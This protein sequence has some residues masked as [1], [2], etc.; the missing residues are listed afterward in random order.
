MTAVRAVLLRP[1]VVLLMMAVLVALVPAR[2]AQAADRRS[3]ADIRDRMEYLVNRERVRHG[4]PRLRVHLAT[5]KRARGHSKDM[6]S[7]GTIYH[8]ANLGNEVPS[9][10]TAYGENVAKT[11]AKDAAG[12]SMTMFM[13]SS[14]HRQNILYSRWSHMGIGIAKRDG[15][16]YVTQRFFDR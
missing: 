8:D 6:A 1:F 11:P 15:N 3:I 14:G 13:D 2:T 7:G 9:N 12:R 16:T 5:Q 4:L 10:A